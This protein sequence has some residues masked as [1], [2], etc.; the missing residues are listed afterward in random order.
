MSDCRPRN[1]IVVGAPRSGTSLTAGIFA[2]CGYF[3]GDISQRHM[4]EGDAGNP[5]GYFEAD[6]VIARNVE[7][8]QRAGFTF[9]NTWLFDSITEPAIERLERMP[10][11]DE[12]RRFVEFYQNHT[13][14]MWK[15]PRL[16]FTLAYWWKFMDPNTTGVVLVRRAFGQIHN[17]FRRRGWCRDGD[18]ARTRLQHCIDRHLEVAEA[19]IG[20]MH[21]PHLEIEYSQCLEN[22]EGVAS[23]LSRFCGCPIAADMLNVRPELNHSTFKGRLAA[24]LRMSL[25][26]GWLRHVRFVRPL[27]PKRLITAVLPEKRY[28][29]PTSE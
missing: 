24:R 2:R 1:I 28:E 10:P 18:E 27:I 25:D 11:S 5:F 3:V 4:R 20:A 22:P 21:I 26:R 6:D 15:D 12:H 9:H 7:L 19:A 17:S 13:P 8:F 16:C 14:W 23:Q 29:K